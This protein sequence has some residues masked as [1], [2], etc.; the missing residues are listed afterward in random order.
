MPDCDPIPEAM[1]HGSSILHGKNYTR[2]ASLIVHMRGRLTLIMI[3][4]IAHSVIVVMITVIMVMIAVM[5][6]VVHVARL[7]HVMR[8]DDKSG[9]G[10][11]RH[12]CSQTQ[13]GRQRKHDDHCPDEGNVAS[14]HLVE[15]R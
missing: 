15:S 12:R 5:M 3:V 14:A 13:Y 8:V 1:S 9:K 6:I 4:R 7:G 11:R 2:A 10:A